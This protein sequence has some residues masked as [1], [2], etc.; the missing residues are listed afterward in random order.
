MYRCKANISFVDI[1]A[2]WNALNNS[3]SANTGGGAEASLSRIQ[4]RFSGLP[5]FVC[6]R[7]VNAALLIHRMFDSSMHAITAPTQLALD[8]VLLPALFILVR[9]SA[10]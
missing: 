6:T 1:G 3:G 2:G 7:P 10:R 8:F 5:M 9:K 4:C